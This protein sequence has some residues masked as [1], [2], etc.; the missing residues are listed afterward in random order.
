MGS[1]WFGQNAE[2]PLADYGGHGAGNI[3]ALVNAACSQYPAA[4]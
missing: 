4:C 2:Y 3:G 1:S